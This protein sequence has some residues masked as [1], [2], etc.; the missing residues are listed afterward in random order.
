[1]SM[2]IR[3]GRR[4]WAN[5]TPSSPVSASI[6]WYPL[7]WRVSRTSLRFLGLS[8]TIR[9]SSFA[10]ADRQGE[11]E[12]R[13]LPGLALHPDPPAMQ[14]DEL[15]GERQP[16]PGPLD[17]LVRRAHLPELLEDRLLI[18]WCDAHA[19]VGDGDLG[20]AVVHRGAHVDPAVLGRELEGVGEQVQE[21][22]LHLPFVTPDHTH[23]VVDALPQ[24]DPAPA[25][26]LT[27]EDQGVVDRGWQVELGH[28][29]FHPAGFDL[30]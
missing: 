15:S 11:R 26:P 6:V 10:M 23:A 25:R 18:L 9:I 30:G 3:A 8:S 29:Q 13:P 12:R 17:L 1:M 22:L 19:G 27:H 16:E 21:D 28:L 2:R 20:Y 4:S 5:C 14:L 7:T 24:P